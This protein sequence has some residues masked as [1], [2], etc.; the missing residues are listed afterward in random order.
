MPERFLF[1]KRTTKKA[2]SKIQLHKPYK[3]KLVDMLHSQL[4]FKK[5]KD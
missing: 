5:K 3:N 1:H 2:N 4:V